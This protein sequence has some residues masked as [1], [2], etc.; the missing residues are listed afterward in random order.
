VSAAREPMAV[1]DGTVVMCP[2]CRLDFDGFADPGEAQDFAAGHNDLHGHG[3]CHG[4]YAVDVGDGVGDGDTVQDGRAAG[5]EPSSG[6]EASAPVQGWLRGAAERRTGEPAADARAEL[7][8][9]V[10]DLQAL[11]ARAPV[12]EDGW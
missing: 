9:R 4:A 6:W 8:A 5:Q 3:S 1:A 12:D 10:E 2:S 11:V 7:D